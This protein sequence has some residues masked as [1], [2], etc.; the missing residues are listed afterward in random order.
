MLQMNHNTADFV[1]NTEFDSLRVMSQSSHDWDSEVLKSGVI[2]PTG[3]FI[4]AESPILLGKDKIYND[5]SEIHMHF[6]DKLK[7]KK[8]SKQIRRSKGKVED[9]DEDMEEEE[10]QDE[11]QSEEMQIDGQD[12]EDQ[13]EEEGKKKSKKSDLI[14]F[15]LS[16]H[17][18]LFPNQVTAGQKA[19]F[20]HQK[21]GTIY[22]NNHRNEYVIYNRAQVRVRYI[23]QLKYEI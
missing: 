3:N 17:P 22:Y 10:D 6:L 12:D 1:N 11:E 19:S 21:Q 15:N 4:N 18:V 7:K 8:K 14:S 5:Y 23:V 9:N 13:D 2:H 16:R 20:T